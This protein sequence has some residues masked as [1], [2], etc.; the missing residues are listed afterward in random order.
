MAAS[1]TTAC[2]PLSVS[3]CLSQQGQGV[4]YLCIVATPR[5]LNTSLDELRWQDWQRKD[6]HDERE[7]PKELFVQSTSGTPF[8][9]HYKERYARVRVCLCMIDVC[10]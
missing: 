1:L 2:Y 6:Y 5:F 3:L 7:A 8:S 9:Y 4:T 10:L